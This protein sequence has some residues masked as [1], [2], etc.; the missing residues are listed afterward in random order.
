MIPT[1]GTRWLVSLIALFLF[2]LP[3]PNSHAK[4]VVNS[5]LSVAEQFTDNL[6]FT[7]ANKQEDFGTFITPT[8]RA[9]FS[10][11]DIKIGA[12]YS[13]SAQ[14]YVNNTRANAVSHGTNFIIDLPFLNRKF[15][16]LEVRVNESFNISPS[17]PAFS[18][19]DSRF[20]GDGEGA[21]AGPGGGAGG[22]GGGGGGGGAGVGGLGGN[23]GLAGN[24]LNNSGIINQRSTGL[25]YRNRA[26][27]LLLYHFN[28]RWD[29]RFTYANSFRGGGSLQ[30]ALT[31]SIRVGWRYKLS[32]RTRLNGGYSPR[33]A[34]FSGGGGGTGSGGRATSHSLYLGANHKLQPTTRV[35]VRVAGTVTDTETGVTRL[36]FTGRASISK[37]IPGGSV[38]L[39]LN[40]GIG[41][42]GGIAA[43]TTLNQT[44]VLTAS[45]SIT[46]LIGSFVNFGYS[47]NRSLSGRI[48]ETDTYQFRGGLSIT[49]L[50][51]LGGGVTYSYRNQDSKGSA[52]NTASSN[53]IF[54]GLTATADPFV[55]FK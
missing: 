12:A 42:G 36:N 49:L 9:T 33:L 39:R 20:N 27:L 7:F 4:V 14:F 22:L 51:W 21:G 3:I 31:H 40:Q 44:A 38:G 48:I 34:V 46:R 28:P 17:L 37:A 53:S 5:S 23:G 16:Q 18:E 35:N 50:D 11:K 2:V 47:R 41:S 29:G 45:K 15:H 26:R 25:S 13:A 32:Q 43:S 19:N 30:N 54:I 10:N 1:S 24:S 52:G 6:F 8:I 55:F